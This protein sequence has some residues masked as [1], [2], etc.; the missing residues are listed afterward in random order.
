VTVF[1]AVVTPG[2][3]IVSPLVLGA[4]M[5]LL[6]EGTIWVIARTGR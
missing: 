4:T 5:Y 2:G 6:F 3:D 1:A